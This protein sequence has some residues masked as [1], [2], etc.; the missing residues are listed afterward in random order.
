[1]VLLTVLK[2]LVKDFKKENFI[3]KISVIFIDMR[4]TTTFYKKKLLF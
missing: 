4:I 2:E 3:L 1:M